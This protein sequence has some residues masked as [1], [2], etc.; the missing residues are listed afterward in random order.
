MESWL[1]ITS[2]LDCQVVK[3][4]E[5]SRWDNIQKLLYT[6][7]IY[8]WITSIP[9]IEYILLSIISIIITF[10]IESINVLSITYIV[11]VFDCLQVVKQNVTLY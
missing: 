8:S 2:V 11:H 9:T 5:D 7:F 1:F 10:Q 6:V 4:T 3:V